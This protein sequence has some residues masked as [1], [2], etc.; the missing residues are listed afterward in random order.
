MNRKTTGMKH[1]LIFVMTMTSLM[2]QLSFGQ[3]SLNE[4]QEKAR[5]N[6]PLIQ[7]FDLIEQSKEYNISNAK[8]AYLPQFD[9]NLIGGIV[10]G[11]PELP[12]PGASSSSELNTQ[13]IGILQFNQVLWDGG[14]TKA[15]KGVITASSEIEKADLEVNLY[16]L[17]DR[18]NGI[19]FGTLLIDEQINQLILL[20]KNLE[21]NMNLVQTAIDGGTAYNTDLDEI[22]VEIM[23]VEQKLDELNYSKMAYLNMLGKMIGIDLPNDQKLIK[24]DVEENYTS[25]ELNRPE[26]KLFDERSNLIESQS[27]LNR[28]SLYPKVGLLA[29]GT[30]INP[31]ISFGQQ[32]IDQILVAGLNLS[33]NIGGLYRNG[34]NKKLADLNNSKI[35]NQRATFLYSTNLEMSKIDQDIAKY[36][37]L[38]ERDGALL[39]LKTKIKKDYDLKYENGVCTLNDLLERINDENLAK[40]NLIVHEIQLLMAVYK[41][42][43]T[44]GNIKPNN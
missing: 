10:E 1:P 34:N 7:Q 44:T 24:P 37:A 31:G 12:V 30:L 3:L 41:H 32:N 17:Y 19:F 27:K 15:K 14:M 16:S 2:T 33:W 26:L 23:N 38:I 28:S 9:V 40:Q 4:C 8:K 6:Y 36:N 18:V 20:K 42:K 39:V 35:A 11:F 21:R 25:T 5:V 43:T 29:F 22:K 13:M